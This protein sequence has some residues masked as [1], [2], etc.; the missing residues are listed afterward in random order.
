MQKR[1]LKKRNKKTSVIFNIIFF[2]L[3]IFIIF[4]FVSLFTQ[5]GNKKNELSDIQNKISEQKTN[6]DELDS[7]LDNGK[8]K[9][10]IEKTAREKLGFV[11]ADE[12]VYYDTAGK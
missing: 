5:L 8:D 1:S 7:V 12:R 3:I 4:S 6:N 9:E 2:V 10:Y 11:S